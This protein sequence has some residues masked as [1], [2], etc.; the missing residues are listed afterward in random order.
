MRE[1]PR[2]KPRGRCVCPSSPLLCQQ[3]GGCALCRGGGWGLTHPQAAI[4]TTD[5]SDAEACVLSASGPGKVSVSFRSEKAVVDQGAI[6]SSVTVRVSFSGGQTRYN[7][8]FQHQVMISFPFLS[9][10]M[11]RQSSRILVF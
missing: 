10:A 3:S 11:Q 1:A 6:V 9:H 7:P 5:L 8:P 4:L 2:Y